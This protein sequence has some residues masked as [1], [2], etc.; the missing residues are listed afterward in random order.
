MSDKPGFKYPAD[1]FA[2]EAARL[3]KHMAKLAET[4][5][6]NIGPGG[7]ISVDGTV[8]FSREEIEV[9]ERACR[10]SVTN[11]RGLISSACRSWLKKIPARQRKRTFV[12]WLSEREGKEWLEL[13]NSDEED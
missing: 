7:F 3:R 12:G 2:G 10:M 4:V 5:G 1:H 8:V 6:E 9:L 11:V 13:L